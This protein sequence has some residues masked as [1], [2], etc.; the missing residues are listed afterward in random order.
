MYAIRS[1][2]AIAFAVIYNPSIEAPVT[3]KDETLLLF[4]LRRYESILLKLET[5]ISIKES[6]LLLFVATLFKELKSKNW[7]TLI[8]SARFLI[9]N[10][11]DTTIVF[12]S[13]V[14]MYPKSTL[15]RITSYNVC[16]TKL[17]RTLPVFVLN[18]NHPK[19]LG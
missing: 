9:A 14:L 19:S 12:L 1:Y 16:Y 2:Y 8:P 11:Y 4:W 10:K 7:P 17:L 15:Y 6:K 18:N 3:I 5:E 13:N